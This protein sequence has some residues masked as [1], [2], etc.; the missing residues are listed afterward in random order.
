M[1]MMTAS[2]LRRSVFWQ[3]AVTDAGF[4]LHARVAS[5]AADMQ[6]V[7]AAE[8]PQRKYSNCGFGYLETTIRVFWH[9]LGTI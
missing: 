3:S 7:V 1:T 9:V 4:Y 8:S 5:T 2:Q 6:G